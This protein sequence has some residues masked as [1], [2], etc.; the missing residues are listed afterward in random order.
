MGVAAGGVDFGFDMGFSLG[1]AGAL[2]LGFSSTY[3]IEDKRQDADFL[4]EFDCAGLVGGT[5]LRPGPQFRFF[6]TTAWSMGSFGV[7]LNWT[8]LDE[9]EQ[10]V[11]SYWAVAVVFAMITDAVELRVD[12][13]RDSQAL[14]V[15]DIKSKTPVPFSLQMSSDC[16][17]INDSRRL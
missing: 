10:D 12:M 9:V 4:P 16:G 11:V 3:V 15:V 6:Q 8:F 17:W 2:D 5:C 13:L 7:Q 1:G 14:E